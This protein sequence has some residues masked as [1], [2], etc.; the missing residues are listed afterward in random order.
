VHVGALK[1][2]D[3]NLPQ[4]FPKI[5]GISWEMVQPGSGGFNQIHREE[6][7][8]EQIIVCPFRSTCEVVILQLDNGAGFAVVYGDAASAR[9]HHEKWA[10]HTVPLNT[11]GPVPFGLRLCPS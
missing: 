4:V 5:D 11:L 2:G 7:D 9:R 6:L 8:D 10:L 3:K 1:I